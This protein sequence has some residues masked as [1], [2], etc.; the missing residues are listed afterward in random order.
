MDQSLRSAAVYIANHTDP[1]SVDV[2]AY[3]Q[4]KEE[5]LR[6]DHWCG[7]RFTLDAARFCHT[8]RISSG[9]LAQKLALAYFE[10]EDEH[11]RKVRDLEYQL[12]ITVQQF[13]AATKEIWKL[14]NPTPDGIPDNY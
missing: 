1:A 11:R 13:N 8:A 12:R 6:F 9:E 3:M 5:P 4:A 10:A 14:K 2:V 7:K